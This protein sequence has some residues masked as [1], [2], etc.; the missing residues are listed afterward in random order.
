MSEFIAAELPFLSNELP[1]VKTVV[2]DLKGGV[3]A[4]LTTPL[5]CGKAINR[6]FSD[7]NELKNMRANLH[8]RRDEYLWK[9]QGAKLV[10]MFEAIGVTS[11]EKLAA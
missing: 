9:W 11:K 4:D 10:R 8:A 2:A 3:I 6:I 5:R 7:P 1:F